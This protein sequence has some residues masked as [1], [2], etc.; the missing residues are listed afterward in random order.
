PCHYSLTHSFT[1]S[2][3]HSFVLKVL[4]QETGHFIAQLSDFIGSGLREIATVGSVD[5][6]TRGVHQQA[7]L[8]V[9]AVLRNHFQV[10]SLGAYAGYKQE[11]FRGETAHAAN[12]VRRRGPGD[13]HQII[14]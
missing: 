13:K 11:M 6:R 8:P 4:L 12:P 1:H 3:I 10:S 7:A 14:W 9:H 5:N 2:L